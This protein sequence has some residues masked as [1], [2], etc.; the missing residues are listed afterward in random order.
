[1]RPDGRS[2]R[3]DRL[4]DGSLFDLGGRL[5]LGLVG[6]AVGGPG[7]ELGRASGERLRVDLGGGL[8]GRLLGVLLFRVL[9]RAAARDAS[10]WRAASMLSTVASRAAI[11]SSAFSS[12]VTNSAGAS[13]MAAT[14]SEAESMNAWTS[15]LSMPSK[16]SGSSGSVISFSS[17]VFSFALIRVVGS[18]CARA[19]RSTLLPGGR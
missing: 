9:G 7:G 17:I 6:V 5:G 18:G 15:S 10:S 4:L 1:L 2:R 8:G 13:A 11:R 16:V 14:A 12:S 19:T 3:G